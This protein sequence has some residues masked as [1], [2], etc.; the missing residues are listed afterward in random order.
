M[1]HCNQENLTLTLTLVVVHV[2]MAAFDN[3]LRLVSTWFLRG[4]CEYLC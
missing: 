1:F 2:L 4:P 3:S